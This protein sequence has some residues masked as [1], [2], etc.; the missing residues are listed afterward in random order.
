MK[1]TLIALAVLSTAGVAA[2]Q[3]SVTLYGVADFGTSISD[4]SDTVETV[5]R[6]G[7]TTKTVTKTRG[8]DVF[9]GEGQAAGNRIGLKGTE[10]LGG[11]IKLGFNYEFGVN[12]D[13]YR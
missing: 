3:S 2:A 1:K 10:D 11:G 9:G 6:G 13:Q 7:S 8:I 4:G 5:K 12:A